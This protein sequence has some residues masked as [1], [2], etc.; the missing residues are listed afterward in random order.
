MVAQA[1]PAVVRIGSGSSVGSGVIFETQGR[2]GYVI[3]NRHVVEGSAEVDVTVN[4]SSSYRGTVLGTDSVRD[5]AV[6]RICC[7]SFRKLGFGDSSRLEPGDEVII[8]GYALGLS[9]E[10][11]VT[12]GIVSAIRYDADYLSD[13]IQTDVAINPGNSGGPMLSVS[14]EIL[15]INTFRIDESH[16]GSPVSGLG[17][18]VSGAT[19]RDLIPALKTAVVAPT[20]VP[21]TPTP[22]P[23]GGGTGGFGPVGGELWH[24]PSDGFVNGEYGGVFMSDFVVTATFFNPYSAAVNSW[25]YGFSIRDTLGS[26]SRELIIAVVNSGGSW[27]LFRQQDGSPEGVDIADGWLRDFDTSAGGSN[28]LQLLAFGEWGLLFVNGDFV[29]MLDLSG[30]TGAGDIAAITGVYEG[31]EVAG[32]VTR[33]ENFVGMPLSQSYGPVGGKLEYEEGYVSEHGSGVWA[34]DFVSEAYFISPSAPWDYGFMFRDSESSRLEV[35]GVDWE[36][37]WFHIARDGG[38]ADG[39]VLHSGFLGTDLGSVNHI[40]LHTV[41][42]VGFFFV[43]GDLVSRLDL[44]HN[45][46]YGFVSAM[47]GFFEGHPGEPRFEG[48]RV[49]TTSGSPALAPTP[50]LAPTRMPTFTPVPTPT[51][52]QPGYAIFPPTATPAAAVPTPVPTAMPMPAPA[53]APTATPIPAP[54]P[55]STATPIPLPTSTPTPV[56]PPTPT[57]TPAPTPVPLLRQEVVFLH[58]DVAHRYSILN[59]GDWFWSGEATAAEGRP[60]LN[61]LVMD[62][63][64]G[65]E[66]F[67]FAYRERVKRRGSARASAYFKVQD[68]GGGGEYIFWEY[69][70]Q[71]EEGDCRYHVVDRAYRSWNAPEDYGF[72]ISTGV[73]EDDLFVY[74]R[75]R[76]EILGSFQEIE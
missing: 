68:S 27:N 7:G 41:E 36:G 65:D 49:W 4:D 18:A 31:S 62:V 8:V 76:D 61:V 53:P 39:S 22:R 14:G 75:E 74:G 43:N 69:I 50:T 29:S 34:R 56:P 40:L 23:F 60:Y 30:V 45:L 20:V 44:S 37:W 72:F 9:G 5:L 54:A 19:V 59:G 57:P 35:V 66:R 26:S 33:F 10:A 13:V 73:C 55:V 25:D 15:G 17:F 28:T 51:V 58:G 6:V 1:R 21:L 48:F 70:W 47:G 64:D 38:D 63:E 32:A 67:G 12:R 71:R 52:R 42:D 3:T 2:T 46:D 11:S 24:D 16:S